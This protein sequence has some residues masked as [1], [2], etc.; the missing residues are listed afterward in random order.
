MTG[1]RLT[2]R[3]ERVRDGIAYGFFLAWVALMAV[4]VC[5]WWGLA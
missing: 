5:R 4:V 3:G 2:R 1:V